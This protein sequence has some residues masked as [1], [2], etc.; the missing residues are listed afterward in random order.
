MT[1]EQ[2]IAV[3]WLVLGTAAG[4]CCIVAA[5]IDLKKYNEPEPEEDSDDE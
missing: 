3:V 5:Y 1:P 4:L 2:S